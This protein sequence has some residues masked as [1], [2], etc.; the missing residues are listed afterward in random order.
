[1]SIREVLR[2]A[3]D[4]G[5]GPERPP[6]ASSWERSDTNSKMKL[7][8]FGLTLSSS[9]GN[10]HATPY[11]AILRALSAMGH[12][13]RFYEKDVAYYRARRDFTSCDFCDLIFYDSW[14]AIRGCALDDA[15]SADVVMTAS[16]LPDGRIINDD[17]LALDRPLRVFYDLDTPVTLRNLAAGEVE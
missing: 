16:Y 17:I 10:G 13:L 8:I 5:C 14:T 3:R 9:W 7:V 2:Y 1:M 12:D 6:S 11:R 4:F 15:R